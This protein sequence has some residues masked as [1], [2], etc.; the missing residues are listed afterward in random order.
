VRA[1]SAARW[2][3]PRIL[4]IEDDAGDQEITRRA[5]SRDGFQ[6]DLRVV[7]DGKEAL[8][9]LFHR[10]RYRDAATSPRPDLILLDL[11]LPGTSGKEVIEAAKGDDQLRSTPVAVV[12]TSARVQDIRESYELGCNSYLIKPLEA[13]RYIG[14]LRDLYTYWFA[15]VALPEAEPSESPRRGLP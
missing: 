14:A 15:L 7:Q 1:R 2:R 13:H 9:Y 5:L 10:G 6:A 3:S 4:L 12:T 11:N 8:D